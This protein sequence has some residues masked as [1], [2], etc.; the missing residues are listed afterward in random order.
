M[1]RTNHSMF[2]YKVI[3]AGKDTIS[4][5]DVTLL[6]CFV[7]EILVKNTKNLESILPSQFGFFPKAEVSRDRRHVLMMRV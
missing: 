4:Y 1:F 6:N 3:D 7:Q 2:E 5:A